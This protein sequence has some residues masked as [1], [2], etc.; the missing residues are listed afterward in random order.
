MAGMCL[1]ALFAV[2]PAM[3]ASG[4]AA[5]APGCG[6]LM[7]MATPPPTYPPTLLLKAPTG[8]TATAGES[9]VT[10]SWSLP[11][12]AK[13]ESVVSYY[14]YQGSS[15]GGTSPGGKFGVTVLGNYQG[16]SCTVTGLT[17]GITYYFIVAM[18]LSD[19]GVDEGEGPSS[20]EVSA[21]PGA[22]AGLTATAGESQVT[23]SWNPPPGGVPVAGYDIYQGTRTGLPRAAGTVGRQ[24]PRAWMDGLASTD[25]I[26]S[27]GCSRVPW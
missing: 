22:P 7:G 8:L 1:A 19:N 17:N 23:L 12:L 4:S 24:R 16:I 26:R 15:P 5:G 18:Q 20:Y 27:P 11:P 10:L 6:S 21:T 14:I 25:R 13:S 3:S 9:Q 2:W